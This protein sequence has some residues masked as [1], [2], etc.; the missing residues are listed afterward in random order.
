M[1]PNVFIRKKIYLNH[2]SCINC[3]YSVKT[4]VYDAVTYSM[5]EPCLFKVCVS[6]LRRYHDF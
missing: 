2:H 6:S 4:A 1:I 5:K 3:G